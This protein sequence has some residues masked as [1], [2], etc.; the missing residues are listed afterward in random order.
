MPAPLASQRVY[1]LP[2]PIRSPR[3]R[4]H[5]RTRPAH[6]SSPWLRC[7]SGD[8]GGGQASLEASGTVANPVS[9]DISSS[10]S[11]CYCLNANDKHLPRSC[12]K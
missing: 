7:S 2:E 5:P 3:C 4:C 10:S 12:E 9:N 1:F 8:N 6:I 11:G